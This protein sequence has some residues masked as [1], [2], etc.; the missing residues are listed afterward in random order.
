MIRT[1]LGVRNRDKLVVASSGGGKVGSRLLE[2]VAHAFRLM[3]KDGSIHLILFTGPL[4][5]DEAFERLQALSIDRMKVFR[6]THDFV[7]YLAAADLS[8]SMAGYNTCMNILATGVR[9]M[10]WPYA[11]NREQ[12]L[13]AGMLARLKAVEMIRGQDLQPVRL[14]SLMDKALAGRPQGKINID[15]EGAANTVRMLRT[16][17]QSLESA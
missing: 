3:Q 5:K 11:R 6:F 16:W 1:Q 17:M 13:R 9:A 15:L 8:V 7:S 10:V 2:T 12:G 14:A 4:I